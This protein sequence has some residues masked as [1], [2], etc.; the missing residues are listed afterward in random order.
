MTGASSADEDLPLKSEGSYLGQIF[1]NAVKQSQTKQKNLILLMFGTG[2][3][4]E[5]G[6]QKQPNRSWEEECRE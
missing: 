5:L 3:V 6:Q 2:L 1:S 4:G